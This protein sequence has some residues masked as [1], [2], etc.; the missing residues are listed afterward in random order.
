[1]NSLTGLPGNPGGC[2]ES[3]VRDGKFYT[4]KGKQHGSAVCLLSPSMVRRALGAVV[5]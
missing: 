1:M 2:Y 3:V 4:E 5:W